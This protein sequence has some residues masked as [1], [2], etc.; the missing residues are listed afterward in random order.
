MTRTLLSSLAG[1]A[2]TAC[3]ALLLVCHVAG[4]QEKADSLEDNPLTPTTPPHVMFHPSIGVQTMW[5]NGD[6]PISRDISPESSSNRDLP[7]GGGVLGSS[8][9]LH[10]GLEVIPSRG[11]IIRFPLSLDAFFLSGKTTYAASRLTEHPVKRWTF[12]HT[13]NIFSAGAG[14]TASFFD[15][16]SLYISAEAKVN[17]IPSTHLTSRIYDAEADTTIRQVDVVPDSSAHWRYGAYIKVGTQVEF[18]E[19]FI[20]DFSVG[21]G[22]LNLWGKNTD[23]ATQRDLMVVDPRNSPETTL[24]YIGIAFSVIWKLD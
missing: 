16:P 6:Y 12:T 4:A 7:L 2:G 14:V 19:P 17:Y 15:L 24:G 9:G 13:G 1:F 10:L 21:Y 22:G 8:N 23:P 3:V 18:F 11:S 20:L 5:F